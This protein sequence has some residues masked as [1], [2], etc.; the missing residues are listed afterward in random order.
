MEVF[1]HCDEKFARV[2]EEF[3]K[4]LTERGDVGASFAATVDGE[5]SFLDYAGKR[6]PW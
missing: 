4:N 1:G 2:R 6:I 5:L 3:E